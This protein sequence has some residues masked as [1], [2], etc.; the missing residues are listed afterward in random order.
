[1]KTGQFIDES[2]IISA[3]LQFICMVSGY[4]LLDKRKVRADKENNN[5]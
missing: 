3:E 5:L 1:V 2:N 4:T